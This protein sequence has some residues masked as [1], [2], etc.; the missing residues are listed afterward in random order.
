[1]KAFLVCDPDA[2]CAVKLA[3]TAS[4]AR[5]AG[6]LEIG[7]EPSLEFEQI[8]RL[9]VRRIPDYDGDDEDA[10]YRRY[11]SEHDQETGD[12]IVTDTQDGGQ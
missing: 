3:D 2:G 11:W 8:T 6:C 7:G 12:W 1:M 5:W 4:K 9:S 10:A